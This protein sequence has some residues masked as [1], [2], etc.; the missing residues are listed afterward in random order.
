MRL[1]QNKFIHK[2][3]PF[4]NEFV[5]ELTTIPTHPYDGLAQTG[6]LSYFICQSTTKR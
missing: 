1:V 6:V 4:P 2:G 3:R 5:D